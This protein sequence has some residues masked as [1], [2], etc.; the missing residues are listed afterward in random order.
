MN[1]LYSMLLVIWPWLPPPISASEIGGIVYAVHDSATVT[2][3][4]LRGDVPQ[5]SLSTE[6]EPQG[7]GQAAV[8]VLTTSWTDTEGVT[9]SVQTPIAATTPAGLE[10]ACELHRVLVNLR[11]RANP[12]KPVQP[13]G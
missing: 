11:Q 10:R 2:A 13:P 5:L 1:W 6:G 7:Q 4:D 9:H 12:P 8:P 3:A